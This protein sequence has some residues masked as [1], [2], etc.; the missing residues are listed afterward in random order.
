MNSH[1]DFI[2]EQLYAL[3]GIPSPSGFTKKVTDYLLSELTALGFAPERSRKG[4][5]FV[6]LGGSGSPLVL[7]AH[8]DTL[9]AMMALHQR[10]RTPS[11]DNPWRSSVVHRRWGELYDSHPGRQNLYRRCPEHRTICTCS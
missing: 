11:P 4:N 5:V 6:T 3:T 8:V 1:M 2:K 9:G 7:A 10:E